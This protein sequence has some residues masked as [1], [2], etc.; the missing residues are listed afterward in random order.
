MNKM[1]ILIVDDVL[2]N[3]KILSSILSPIEEYEIQMASNG[4][5]VIENIEDDIPD[6]ILLD[7]MMPD[8]DGFGLIDYLKSKDNL[9]DVPVIFITALD[10][11]EKKVEAFSKGGIDYITKPFHMPEL[12]GR[13]KNQL[14]IKNLQNELKAKNS[15]LSEREKHLEKLVQD[16]TEKL[17][18]MTLSIV[19]A[20]EDANF[21]NDTDTGN[22]IR[23]VSEYSAI[24]AQGYGCDEEFIKKIKL[25]ASLHDV[26]KVGI[27]D[28]LLKK[29]GKYT[30]QERIEMQDHVRI[31]KKI[32]EN[33]GIDPMAINIAYYHH[34]KWDGTGYVNGL[35]E[36]EI[37]LEARIVA[38]A[39]VYDALMSRRSY[40]APFS[41]EESKSF[42]LTHA[43]SHFEKKLIDI[44]IDK[45]SEFISVLERLS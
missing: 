11:L 9:K 37:P 10:S 12:L 8:I 39:D 7:I 5:S 29:P 32:L 14:M 36:Y 27:S 28:N 33:S 26:G 23:R 35:K 15:L 42:L 31:G 20:L 3:R 21:Y 24:L 2:E 43:G 4:N 41:L 38:V 16:K 30:D 25:F 22:H 19:T 34:E 1:K 18:S 40:K 13:V 44:F 17:E 6:L 45:Y